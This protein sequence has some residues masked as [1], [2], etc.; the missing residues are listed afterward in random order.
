M[1]TLIDDPFHS[2]QSRKT[3]KW[4]CCC[5]PSPSVS[6]SV[7]NPLLTNWVHH[8]HHISSNSYQQVDVPSLFLSPVQGWLPCWLVL[9]SMMI[10]QCSA[11][12]QTN[13]RTNEL[14]SSQMDTLT[15]ANTEQTAVINA[16]IDALMLILVLLR[17]EK[18]WEGRVLYLERPPKLASSVGGC[19]TGRNNS[20]GSGRTGLRQTLGG[21]DASHTHV[22]SCQLYVLSEEASGDAEVGAAVMAIQCNFSTTATSSVAQSTSLDI[23]SCLLSCPFLKVS[24]PSP[25][26]IS[27]FF[28]HPFPS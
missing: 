14:I 2:R 24:S 18:E 3:A 12:G 7:P 5:V 25:V 10:G 8:S 11:G 4:L 17:R 23:V 15:R 16:L 28:L 26:C 20:L 19:Q 22:L 21:G 27:V 9:K 6:L 1:S 13:R